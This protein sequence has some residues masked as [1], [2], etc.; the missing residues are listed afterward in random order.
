MKISC[1]II[2]DLLPLYAENMTSQASSEMV[3]THLGECEGC[4]NYLKEPPH[5]CQ[6]AGTDNGSESEPY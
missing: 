3:E 5:P 4:T 2:R 6:T 1:D